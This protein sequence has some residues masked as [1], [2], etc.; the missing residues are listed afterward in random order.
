MTLQTLKDRLLKSKEFRNEYFKKDLAFEIGYM[1]LNA[2]I[3]KKMT[4]K[5]LAEKI[6]TKQPSIARVES[7]EILPSLSFLEKVAHAFDSYLIPPTFGFMSDYPNKEVYP[8]SSNPIQLIFVNA[9]EAANFHT[10]NE[11]INKNQLISN[12][13]PS[14][15][16]TN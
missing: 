4:Q 3:E 5:E 15:V 2:R 1:I 9:K 16:Q 6:G 13:E 14:Y 10:N 12:L 11:L 7:G 8:S